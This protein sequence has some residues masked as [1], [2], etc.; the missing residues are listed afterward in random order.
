[1]DSPLIV[2]AVIFIVAVVLGL[3][4]QYCLPRLSDSRNILFIIFLFLGIGS[5]GSCLFNLA[6]LL[7]TGQIAHGDVQVVGT[8]VTLGVL[9]KPLNFLM[10]KLDDAL[11]KK[12]ATRK[13]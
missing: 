8:F 2:S 9:W 1:M 13:N 5:G 7:F 10:G 12:D 11:Q 3:W 4:S 6:H